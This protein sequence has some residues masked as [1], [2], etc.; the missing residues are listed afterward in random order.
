MTFAKTLEKL[1]AKAK[2][3]RYGLARD[4]E[5][6]P[7]YVARLER[8]EKLHPSR[9]MV[10]RLG[11]ALLDNSADVSLEDIDRLL[12]AAGYSPLPRTRISILPRR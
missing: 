2:L 11:Q 3:T 8:G 1:R 10:L 7:G 9:H 12:K 4:A 6:D 5:V